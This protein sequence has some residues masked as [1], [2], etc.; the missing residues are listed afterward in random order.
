MRQ[1]YWKETKLSTVNFIKLMG[2]L[3]K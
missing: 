3:N 1:R 2:K